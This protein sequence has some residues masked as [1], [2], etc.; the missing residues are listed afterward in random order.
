VVEDQAGRQAYTDPVWITLQ[1]NAP[2]AV[3]H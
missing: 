1:G 2:A 3:R